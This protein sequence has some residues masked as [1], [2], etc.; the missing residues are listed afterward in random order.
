MVI[1]AYNAAAY[2][3]G[4]VDSVLAQSFRDLEV[5]VVDDGSS[6]ETP[7]I[8]GGY[9]RP[10]RCVR[11]DNRGV[12]SAR[13]RGIEEGRGRFVAFLDA[14]DLWRPE[15]LERQL[16]ALRARPGHRACA[17]AFTV[18]DVGL[19]PLEVHRI[20]PREPG[21]LDLLLRGNVIGT[22]STVLCERSLLAEAGG[23]DPALSQC[24]DWE[25]WIR[26]RTRTAFVCLDEPLAIYRRHAGNMSRSVALL[27][28]DS[29]GVLEK[30][31]A[32][33]ELP[34]G[35]RGRR[36]E[37]IARNAMVL[38]GSYFQAGLLADSARC[39]SLAL[40]LDWRQAGHLAAYP[41]RALGRRLRRP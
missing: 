3:A 40:R 13:N 15:K 26:L 19:T 33:P 12:A 25:L 31:F 16:G 29:T 4:A 8:L 28:R 1:P 24:A 34:D 22:P 17:S 11:Q 14:D 36:R 20:E 35:L 38:A 2:V 37:A 10:V 5:V 21:L 6:D 9:D 30:A 18:V 32:L 39:T 41:W 27:E 7:A 23:F